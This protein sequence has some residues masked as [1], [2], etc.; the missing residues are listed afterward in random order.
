[1]ELRNPLSILARLRP[2]RLWLPA[3]LAAA[4]LAALPLAASA[5]P[6]AQDAPATTAVTVATPSAWPMVLA[7]IAAAFAIE[8]LLEL[9]W[10]VVQW[11]GL[12]TRRG[13]PASFKTPAFLQF[14][15]GVSVLLGAILGVLLA[16]TMNLHFFA[17]LSLMVPGFTLNIPANWDVVVTGLIIGVGAKPIHDLIGLLYELKNFMGNAS[18][19]QREAAGAAM[20][21]GVL[22]LAQSEAESMIEVPGMG[23]TPLTGDAYTGASGAAA[24]GSD[25]STTDKYIDLL[26]QRTLS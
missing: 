1:M 21:D 18:I 17:A 26:H 12:S 8:R 10:N 5:A 15:S 23:R 16:G 14:K 22:K 24:S 13:Q 4:A 19:R 2:A 6:P 3:L 7:M 11:V 9:L 20:A 25:Q